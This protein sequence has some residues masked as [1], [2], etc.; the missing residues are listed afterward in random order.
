MK[1]M[2]GIQKMREEGYQETKYG[3]NK[4]KQKENKEIGKDGREDG[5]IG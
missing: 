2:E 3:R 5:M 4:R 1:K